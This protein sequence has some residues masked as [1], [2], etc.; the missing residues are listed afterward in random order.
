MLRYAP[1]LGSTPDDINHSDM[2]TL[3]SSVK[4]LLK[5]DLGNLEEPTRDVGDYSSMQHSRAK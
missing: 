3:P 4:L 1:V 5:V 2:V